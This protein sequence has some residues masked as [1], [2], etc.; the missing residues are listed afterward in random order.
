MFKLT[1][2]S[3]LVSF[4]ALTLI[5][6]SLASEKPVTAKEVALV[7]KSS[8]V[9]PLDTPSSRLASQLLAK[10]RVEY[11]RKDDFLKLK[12]EILNASG[13]AVP[14]LIEV[15][16]DSK[17]PDKN[18]WVATFL[19][20]RIMGEKAAP[21]IA[22]FVEHPNWIMRMAA[23]KTLLALRQ[24]KYGSLYA[25][26]LADEAL[27][28]RFQ[29]L[30]N[31]KKLKLQKYAPSVWAML[32]DQQNYYQKPS[33]KSRRGHIVKEVITTIGDLQFVEARAPL[34]KMVQKEKYKDIFTEMDYS[35]E[36]ITG[37]I[38]PKGSEQVK[39][40]YWSR[41]ALSDKNL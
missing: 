7:A 12:E 26:S 1:V 19:L 24:A 10:F 11:K 34:L 31:I 37:K 18:R 6:S 36:K 38:S 29:A 41:L 33:G 20:G 13:N 27:L 9:S 32:Y 17:Y 25:K 3:V 30:D 35:L 40:A 2:S 22:K 16:K 15:M 5:F 39:R 21:F 8:D 4:V 28:V 14:V 23:L